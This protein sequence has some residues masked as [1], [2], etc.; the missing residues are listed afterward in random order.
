[1]NQLDKVDLK[2]T[3]SP[4]KSIVKKKEKVAVI[5]LCKGG[6]SMWLEGEKW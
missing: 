1:M 3:K 4:F 5:E 6:Y 2:K